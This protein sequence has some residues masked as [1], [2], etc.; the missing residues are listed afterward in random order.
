M[1]ISVFRDASGCAPQARLPSGH[2]VAPRTPRGAAAPAGSPPKVGGGKHA[3][4]AHPRA[5]D[6]VRRALIELSDD[7][8]AVLDAA[9]DVYESPSQRQ[10]A[11]ERQHA[12]GNYDARCPLTPVERKHD[13]G[14]E[15]S[16]GISH[17]LR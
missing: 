16:C 6:A 1:S 11:C 9:Y 8:E 10:A 12:A 3:G 7:Q 13:A 2:Q 4:V 15:C 14:E 5:Q 17:S